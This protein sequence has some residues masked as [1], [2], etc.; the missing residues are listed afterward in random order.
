MNI[1]SVKI[2]NGCDVENS[3]VV[4]LG[5]YNA[6]LQENI[7]LKQQTKEAIEIIEVLRSR[8]Y[9]RQVANKVV[10]DIAEK[11][12]EENTNES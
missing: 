1:V 3:S 8:L 7:K 5:D 9:K 12:L 4:L 6:L 10:L 2:Y 11:F